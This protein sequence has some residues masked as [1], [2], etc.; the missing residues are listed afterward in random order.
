MRLFASLLPSLLPLLLFCTTSFPVQVSGKIFSE[1]PGTSRVV[2]GPA[3]I[4]GLES[5]FD[6]SLELNTRYLGERSSAQKVLRESFATNVALLR[7]GLGRRLS[8]T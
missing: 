5:A 8:P 3:L 4:K 7:S 2:D 1:P 6:R